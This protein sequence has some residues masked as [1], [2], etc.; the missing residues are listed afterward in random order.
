M[1]S[2]R[3][4]SADSRR[5]YTTQ[6]RATS[7]RKPPDG[8]RC[9]CDRLGPEAGAGSSRLQQGHSRG[10]SEQDAEGAG[11][12]SCCCEPG[13]GAARQVEPLE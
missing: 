9:R 11:V 3:R 8:A 2:S 6:P 1:G 4:L 5:A 12:V 13:A 10:W 7:V